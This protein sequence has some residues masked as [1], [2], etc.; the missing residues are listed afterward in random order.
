MSSVHHPCGNSLE[1]RDWI[2]AERIEAKHEKTYS[3][4]FRMG[5]LL[6]LDCSAC[7]EFSLCLPKEQW[8]NMV[9]FQASF[10]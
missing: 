6:F 7:D 2:L 3:R 5:L 8:E 9:V 10:R 1:E 4:N